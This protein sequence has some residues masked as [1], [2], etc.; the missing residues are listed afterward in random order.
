[1][2]AP[3]A[4]VINYT[5]DLRSMTRGSGSYTLT[6]EGYEQAPADVTKKLVEAYEAARAAGKTAPAQTGSRTR[7]I[8]RNLFMDCI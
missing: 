3:Y 1:M 6:L 8:N 2:R 7:R 5:K 4:E